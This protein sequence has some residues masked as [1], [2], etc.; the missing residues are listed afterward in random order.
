M[1]DLAARGARA[2]R[3]QGPRRARRHRHGRR[4]ARAAR[5]ARRA[6]RPADRA[7][8]AGR[9]RSRAC[10]R[11]SA[12]RRRRAGRAA[13]CG[14]AARGPGRRGAAVRAAEGAA[15]AP[16]SRPSTRRSPGLGTRLGGDVAARPGAGAAGGLGA[17]LYWLGATGEP[18][19]DAVARIVGLDEALRGATLCLTA[20]GAVDRQSARGKTV[21]A[22]AHACARAGVACVVLGGR[23]DARGRRAARAAR[24]ARARARAGRSPAR[25]GARRDERRP[26][27]DRRGAERVRPWRDIRVIFVLAVLA[28]IA[29]IVLLVESQPPTPTRARALTYRPVDA[30]AIVAFYEAHHSQ[31]ANERTANAILRAARRHNVNPG[32]ARRDHR[33]GAELRPDGRRPAHREEPVQRLRL[34]VQDDDPD[35]GVGRG[36]GGHGRPSPAVRAA[37]SP[38]RTSSSGSTR[39][40]TRA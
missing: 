21:A 34:L 25:G 18:G 5:R 2:G 7:I 27:A 35:R 19:A 16:T 20:E 28:T 38:A 4:R 22:V 14:R 10:R 33:P 6:A 40:P 9:S 39:S 3:R 23:V 13:R 30:A 32:R 36:R 29:V 12:A 1:G 37:S 15:R 26:R 11:R 17:A 31:L 24:R 8:A